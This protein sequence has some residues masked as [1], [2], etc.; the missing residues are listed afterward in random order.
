MVRLMR[1]VTNRFR[2]ENELPFFFG[3]PAILWQIIFFIVPLLAILFFSVSVF[4]SQGSLIG[5]SF[6]SFK[7]F[8]SMPY[9]WVIL[10]SL[11]L[12]FFNVSV[13]FLVAYPVAYYLV[14][15]A[16]SFKPLLFFLLVLPF[17]TNFLLHIFAWF[18]VLEKEGFLNLFL[19]SVGLISKPLHLLNSSFAVYLMMVYYYLP[20]MIL[21]LYA[22]LDRFDGDLIEASYD[23]GATWWQTI[24]KIL[25]P[26][27]AG[28][29]VT[30]FFMVFVPSFGEF[31]IPELLG[32][33]K[34]MY[35]GNVVSYLVLGENTGALGGA[36]TVLSC[37]VL[38]L[39]AFV[40]YLGIVRLIKMLK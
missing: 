4:N 24:W 10:R 34:I 39:S 12:A 18:F 30:G 5:F 38:G 16:G 2:G 32:G 40:C 36:F 15:R 26:S 33:D 29:I 3:T 9:V 37:L 8:F 35:V 14:F 13:C 19:Q 17:W 6:A 23:L 25:I 1:C 31:V 21:P 7:Y 22:A 27:T 11:W 28:G 20:F